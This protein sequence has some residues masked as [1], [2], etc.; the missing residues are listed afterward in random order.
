MELRSL[1]ERVIELLAP[2]AHAKD[3]E[4]VAITPT[5]V[6]LSVRTDGVRLLQVL[7]NLV[8][9]AVKF[10]EK[11]GVRVD[12]DDGRRPRAPLPALRSAR[13]RR[14]RAGRKAQGDLRGIRPG[15]FQPR[16][17]IRRHRPWSCD[18]QAAGRRPWAARSASSP[19]PERAA[20]S[21]SRFPRSSS[22]P[23]PNFRRRA[24]LEDIRFAIITRNALLR[25]GLTAQIRAAGGEVGALARGRRSR[26]ADRLRARRRRHRRRA[27]SAR[28]AGRAISRR[29]VLLAPA[30]HGKLGGDD[31]ERLCGLSGQAGPPGL[32]W[33]SGISR[34]AT[35]RSSARAELRRP[36][37]ARRCRRNAALPRIAA[38]RSFWPRTI[39]STRC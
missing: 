37:N 9:N 8:G 25:E 6:P 5:D 19:R 21:G 7:N 23:R 34:S 18:L 3:I 32:A 26:A 4:L 30:A 38:S 12:V 2:R 17:Q 31:G 13:Y 10:T 39:R 16:A 14:R 35:S 1:V 20:C 29:F 24:P 15:R 36:R 22:P 27:R 33:W 11:G 28:T